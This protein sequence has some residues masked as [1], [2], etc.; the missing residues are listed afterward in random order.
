VDLELPMS[1]ASESFSDEPQV[2]S[3][4][5]GPVVLAGDLGTRGLTDEL[6]LDKQGLAVEKLPAKVPE[7]HA[8]GNKLEDWIKPDGSA[9][10]TFRAAG[11]E[12]GV[13]LRP[14]NQ[15]W[16]RYATYWNVS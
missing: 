9:P 8:S 15:L 12:G 13:T 11:S 16:G 1:L 3:F 4:L 10:R 7:L 5:Y 2:Q 6:I 14:L